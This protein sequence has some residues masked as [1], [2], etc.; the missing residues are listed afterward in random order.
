MTWPGLLVRWLLQSSA[1][2][3]STRLAPYVQT[4]LATGIPFYIGEGNSV[5]CGGQYNISDVF[6]AT[7][8]VRL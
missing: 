2:H 8:W 3:E 6:G 5:S 7:L 1:N 4:A